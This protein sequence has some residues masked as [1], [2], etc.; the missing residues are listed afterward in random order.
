MTTLDNEALFASYSDLL[1]N[2]G[3]AYAAMQETM[4]S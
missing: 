3:A 1:A 4:K 2:F